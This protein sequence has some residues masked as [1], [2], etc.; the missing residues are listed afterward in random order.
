MNPSPEKISQVYKHSAVK[1]NSRDCLIKKETNTKHE[2][3][4]EKNSLMQSDNI[5]T[6]PNFKIGVPTQH[7][8]GEEDREILSINK[9]EKTND[10]LESLED[11]QI[12]GKDWK[13][14]SSFLWNTANG[15][16]TN[17][18]PDLIRNEQSSWTTTR[19]SSM[20]GQGSKLEQYLENGDD[21]Y[22]RI[23]GGPELYDDVGV[24]SVN[25]Q[26]IENYKNNPMNHSYMDIAS[27][28]SQQ[29]ETRKSSAITAS[30]DDI[31]NLSTHIHLTIS[32]SQENIS[33][34]KGSP[35]YLSA[36][37][38]SSMH[39]DDIGNLSKSERGP[40]ETG[41]E[42]TTV[43]SSVRPGTA[44]HGMEDTEND[45]KLYTSSCV[46]ATPAVILEDQHDSISYLYDDISTGSLNNGDMGLYESIA[47]SILNL[48]KTKLG[49]SFEDLYS[50][51]GNSSKKETESRR[52]SCVSNRSNLGP[53]EVNSYT[54]S[55]MKEGQG[56][57][58]GSSEGI[59][60]F[61]GDVNFVDNFSL[62]GS[63]RSSNPSFS[64]LERKS[65]TSDRSD[66][67]VDI[68]T[69][70]FHHSQLLFYS[71]FLLLL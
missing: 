15:L 31:S 67:W 38:L 25:Y 68:E 64:T 24:G 30:Y 8:T 32:K 47:G 71:D 46:K 70:K 48:A 50:S 45:E 36:D 16:P 23:Q 66:E 65:I 10:I 44:L 41:A 53:H 11:D 18:D 54:L 58:I 14:N 34:N 13:P 39:Y 55:K 29:I 63:N 17:N 4:Q 9:R 5:P 27:V 69:G 35:L 33:R 40:G 49:T 61:H 60:K 62:R 20:D 22:E 59:Y 6:V 56:L 51:Y 3:I 21:L 26:L 19:D 42:I 52:F 37:N 12:K 2:N 28:K 7:D 57:E 1:S 43:D